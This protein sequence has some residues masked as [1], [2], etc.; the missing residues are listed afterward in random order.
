[1]TKL[2]GL[3]VKSDDLEIDIGG[4]KVHPHK[5][6]WVEIVP[7]R[8]VAEYKAIAALGG[9]SVVLDALK[10]EADEGSKTVIAVADAYSGLCEHLA[11]RVTDWNWTDVFG[12][13][14]PKPDG[15]SGPMFRLS[16]DEL[17]WLANAGQ[18]ETVADRKN[19]SRPSRTT[20]SATE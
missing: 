1:M 6:E 3:R 17:W 18:G 4:T 5:G 10:G 13:P 20:R 2:P 15:T 12:K 8:T 19:G 16:Q 14:M 7:T 11:S 9:L